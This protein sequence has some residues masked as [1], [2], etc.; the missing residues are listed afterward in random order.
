MCT[1]SPMCGDYECGVGLGI[2]LWVQYKEL[3]CDI[4]YKHGDIS[5]GYVWGA[6][7]GVCWMWHME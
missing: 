6:G 3:V 5:M 2:G 1:A 7:C 4:W